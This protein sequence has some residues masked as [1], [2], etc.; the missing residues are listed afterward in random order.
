MGL[1]HPMEGV[2]TVGGIE[3]LTGLGTQGLDVL[4]SP[5]SPITDD[6]QAPL[7]FRLTFRTFFR[8]SEAFWRSLP[9]GGEDELYVD[10]SILCNPLFLGYLFINH[11]F[12]QTGRPISDP[13]G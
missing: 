7:L 3:H 2:G 6:A 4:P 9:Q 1:G 8:S 10:Y 5:P 12:I 13:P 11:N